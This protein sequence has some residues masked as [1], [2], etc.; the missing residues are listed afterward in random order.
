MDDQTELYSKWLAGNCTCM[1]YLNDYKKCLDGIPCTEF[2]ANSDKKCTS[3]L[4]PMPPMSDKDGGTSIPTNDASVSECSSGESFCE[5]STAVNC[6]SGKFSR[7]DC[8]QEGMRC[9]ISGGAAD[10]SLD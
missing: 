1:T 4:A 10:C 2:L 8:A 7:R 5:G 6:I 3:Y 9:V